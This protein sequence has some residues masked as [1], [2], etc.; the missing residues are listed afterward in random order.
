MMPLLEKQQEELW[1]K[2]NRIV[3]PDDE[4]VG[5]VDG[6]FPRNSSR[7]WIEDKLDMLRLHLQLD[8]DLT[9]LQPPQVSVVNTGDGT[10]R[11]LLL[12]TA[13]LFYRYQEI[14]ASGCFGH[15]GAV[16]IGNNSSSS[17]PRLPSNILCGSN[18]RISE[19][20]RCLADHRGQVQG[21][22][23]FIFEG[24][25]TLNNSK[26]AVKFFHK[27]DD[28]AATQRTNMELVTC[29]RLY[30]GLS[31][32]DCI[33]RHD[34]VDLCHLLR[35]RDVLVDEPLFEE[36][37][38]GLAPSMFRATVMVFDWADGGDAHSLVRALGRGIPHAAGARLFQQVLRGLRALHRRRIAH[39]DI[40]P[41]NILLDKD[42]RVAR[43]C[44]F[45]FAKHV[46]SIKPTDLAGDPTTCYQPP[47]RWLAC[48]GPSAIQAR[49]KMSRASVM[50]DESGRSDAC[51]GG[52]CCGV[53]R[54]DETAES[55]FA[56]DVFSAGVTLFVL[57]SYHAILARLVTEA[58]CRDV[59]EGEE[60]SLPAM[61]IFQHAAGGELFGLL[62][63]RKEK[64][65]VQG[66]L[67]AYW[68]VYGLEL[69]LALRGLLD[70]VLHP[71]PDRRFSLEEAFDWMDSHP[72]MF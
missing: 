44:D 31:S 10:V 53:P 29:L 3:I 34:E 65:G 52:E 49:D 70:G 56:G 30:H 2:S 72:E 39:R 62:Q 13:D 69:P 14:M 19:R 1:V 37:G 58:G 24:L 28:L 20:Y 25:D 50:A 8:S 46:P 68:E 4:D 23:G 36:R 59:S 33:D 18:F 27:T 71:V 60:S 41:E 22:V 40:K 12:T 43:V 57:V 21:G 26:V 66:R 6:H 9:R 16:G 51:S 38:V 5:E 11:C 47:E 55:L 15:Q 7:S 32:F 17:S 64:G 63:A 35:L 45:G 48:N 61:N 54:R 42:C 67:W